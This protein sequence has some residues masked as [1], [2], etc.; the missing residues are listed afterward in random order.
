MHKN[1]TQAHLL[2]FIF[3]ISVSL[4][5]LRD[6]FIT[7]SEFYCGF[8]PTSVKKKILIFNSFSFHMK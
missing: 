6:K 5:D 3:S 8:M 7:E 2:T 1:D 4:L